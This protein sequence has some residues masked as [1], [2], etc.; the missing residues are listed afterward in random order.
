MNGTATVLWALVGAIAS[1]VLAPATTALT[2]GGQRSLRSKSLIAAITASVFGL[3]AARFSAVEE[4]VVFSV[5]AAVGVELAVVDVL[6]LRLPRA[7]VWPT[8]ATVTGVIAAA[9]VSADEGAT[10]LLRALIGAAILIGCYFAIA[11]ASSGG[12][13]AGDVRTAGLVGCVL[14]WHS[15]PALVNGTILAFFVTASL[16]VAL[17]IFRHRK[18]GSVPH[19]PGMMAGAFIALLI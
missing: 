3:I 16:A 13:G 1:W 15:W 12:M 14:G 7:M 9:E 17:A 11:L 4:L 19:G 6:V 10:G 5:F 18:D 2:D 8:W